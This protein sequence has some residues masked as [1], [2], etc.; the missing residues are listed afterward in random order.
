MYKFQNYEDLKMKILNF[1][2]NLYVKCS[3]K[4]FDYYTS[5]EQW[6]NYCF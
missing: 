2:M 3:I 6:L 4:C 5:G 1:T